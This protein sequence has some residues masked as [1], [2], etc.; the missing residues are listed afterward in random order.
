MELI[1]HYTQ[2]LLS[3]VN[4]IEITSEDMEKLLFIPLSEY[5]PTTSI[6][7]FNLDGAGITDEGNIDDGSTDAYNMEFG[8]INNDIDIK[9]E[10]I[11]DSD[12]MENG[13]IDNKDEVGKIADNN[14]SYRSVSITDE[15]KPDEIG[16]ITDNNDFDETETDENKNIDE[17][18][19]I[20][21]E[22][23]ETQSLDDNVD[24]TYSMHS[25]D[26][27][28][29]VMIINEKKIRKKRDPMMYM[30]CSQCPIKYRF[31][32]KLKHHM[33]T[34]HSIDLYYCKVCINFY[35][36]TTKIIDYSNE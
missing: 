22:K 23:E 21:V 36:F 8:S 19:I 20:V 29:M 9:N 26:D 35:Y 34:V 14:N 17:N 18:I 31:V 28:E 13:S 12:E 2:E 11:A 32:A 24:S 5:T 33:K 4:N 3:N 1:T 25:S 6:F 10:S 7:D 27:E 16:K 30:T 15:N